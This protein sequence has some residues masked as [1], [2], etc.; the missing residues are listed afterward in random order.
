[1]TPR[2]FLAI[3]VAACAAW[4]HT[5]SAERQAPPPPLIEQD[6]F[7]FRDGRSQTTRVP[8]TL[9]EGGLTLTWPDDLPPAW[10]TALLAVT[11]TAESGGPAPLI[12]IALDEVAARQYIR[13]GDRGARWIDLS[14]LRGRVRARSTVRLRPHGVSLEAADATLRVFANALDLSQPMLVL[15]PHPDDAEIAA[16]ALYNRRRATVVTVT[17]GNAGPPTY[18]AVFDSLPDLYRFKG[19]LRVIDSITVPWLGG[20]PPERTFNL[21][22]FDARLAEMHD[23][24]GKVI[25]EMYATNTDIG[26]Y[27]RENLGSLLS[28]RA[29]SSSWAN[30]VEDVEQ[31]LRRVKPRVIVAPHPQLDSHRDHQFTTV[32]LSQA[33]AKWRRPVTLLLYTNHADQNRYPYGPAGTLMSLPPPTP[34]GA[35]LDRVYSH[36]VSPDEQR[37]K[38]FA[39]EAMHDLRPS[40]SR[41]YQL[42]VGDGRVEQPEKEGPASGPGVGY[43]R[44]GPRAN[45]L[46]Y[47]YDRD[48][49]RPML[50]AFLAAWRARPPS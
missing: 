17:S 43:L 37:L 34:Q 31:V 50:D 18:E 42:V 20:I 13:P 29:R 3:V 1:M 22:Y 49:V 33:L 5:A 48:S 4:A 10:D 15:A 39:L 21:G 32:A 19:R 7:T 46:F 6:T 11:V 44:R 41:V 38:L 23:H 27:R 9:S 26:V 35:I 28:T 16:F 30:L 24:P 8:L 25:P 2:R 14:A 40:P 47:V 45:E 36:P 12:E